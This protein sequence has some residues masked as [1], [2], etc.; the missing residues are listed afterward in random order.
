LLSAILFEK[1]VVQ[2]TTTVN[3]NQAVVTDS[4]VTGKSKE[5]ASSTKLLAA[6][7]E[8]PMEIREPEK[9]NEN[10]PSGTYVLEVRSVRTVWR[11]VPEVTEWSI[12][13]PRD[14]PQRERPLRLGR[15][16]F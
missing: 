7:T 13:L 4:V 6:V 16:R 15:R 12:F 5:A 10:D 8:N 3:A 11:D 2:H 9:Q 1:I 14:V